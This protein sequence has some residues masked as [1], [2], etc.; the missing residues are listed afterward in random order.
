MFLLF[1]ELYNKDL[2]S[3][4]HSVYLYYAVSLMVSSRTIIL[5]GV[6]ICMS[7]RVVIKHTSLVDVIITAIINYFSVKT[8]STKLYSL[9]DNLAS[10]SLSCIN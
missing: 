3:Y 6:L 1:L 8:S 10:I 2:L 7:V 9:I 5:L 4:K